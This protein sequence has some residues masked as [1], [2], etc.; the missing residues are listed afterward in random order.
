[1]RPQGRVVSRGS[2]L[3]ALGG[4][5]VQAKP[6]TQEAV[7][8]R[9]RDGDKIVDRL[10]ACPQDKVARLGDRDGDGVGDGCDAAP[11]CHAR[12]T[13]G[14]FVLTHDPIA[15]PLEQW[16]LPAVVYGPLVPL[17]GGVR[18]ATGAPVGRRAVLDRRT[19]SWR[20]L[21]ASVV[22]ASGASVVVDNLGDWVATPGFGNNAM[23]QEGRVLQ[24]F[25]EG[26]IEQ[27]RTVLD[28][29]SYTQLELART[30]EG[31]M[32]ALTTWEANG[33][34]NV[35][36]GRYN[37]GG[38]L[39]SALF[40]G[41]FSPMKWQATS[42]EG[43]GVAFYSEPFLNEDVLQIVIKGFPGSSRAA[44]VQERVVLGAP[45]D[46]LLMVTEA[47][48][49]VLWDKS[50]GKG[51]VLRKAALGA[52]YTP[53]PVPELDISPL[54][55]GARVVV[56]PEAMA[57]VVFE[58]GAGGMLEVKEVGF[59]CKLERLTFDS[60]MDG[61]PDLGDN[62][63][64][65]VN[66]NQ[67]DL[68]GD[69]QGDGCD[70][71][72]DGDG[73]ADVV[74]KRLKR[75]GGKDL[76]DASR[77]T[78]NDG[79]D[80]L[81]DPDDD[82]DGI[83]DETDRFPLDTD[84]DSSPNALDP[85]DD[86]D[87]DSDD[88]ERTQGSDPLDAMDFPQS[89]RLVYLRVAPG[90]GRSVEW[91]TF[92][93]LVQGKP[94]VPIPALGTKAHEPSLS[95]LGQSVLVLDGPP[96]M[97]MGVRW[98]QLVPPSQSPTRPAQQVELGAVQVQAAPQTMEEGGE[99]LLGVTHIQK[100]SDGIR[101]SLYSSALSP[102]PPQRVVAT[103]ALVERPG[104]V[105]A[106]YRGRSRL[107]VVAAPPGCGACRTAYEVN[108]AGRGI[109]AV[110]TTRTDVSW[111][112]RNSSER[113]VKASWVNE[114]GVGEARIFR[115]SSATPMRLPPGSEEVGTLVPMSR[116]G[117][118]IVTAKDASTGRFQLWF[119][120]DGGGRWVRLTESAE[121]LQEVDWKP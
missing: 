66:A 3:S 68:D 7:C 85:D 37:L 1:M 6:G 24:M 42:W 50:T 47:G 35:R 27:T 88:V 79:I 111:V 103:Q 26:G 60:D 4:T 20:E 82:G 70:E 93:D 18:A 64:R 72:D 14:E 90:G 52:T 97:A 89:G 10:D 11:L 8:I 57:L 121:S 69:G 41:T 65:V 25:Q 58:A 87:G 44:L 43:G 71:D 104:E 33:M 107:H 113:W 96:G 109:N 91:I 12:M 115:E 75:A 80:N 46:P 101:T 94:A 9:D 34:Q 45:I 120:P 39:T 100:H 67:A 73:L 22:D 86:E 36:I 77:D 59:G 99:V 48:A 98:S 92:G 74:D 61:V 21:E 63:P 30:K 110:F 62:C 17:I 116:L 105:S 106:L 78:D 5:W 55:P 108:E 15:W 19:G 40:T 83:A 13:P 32:M 117:R 56:A 2:T 16:G 38:A 118:A 54:E 23:G 119:T 51:Y 31:G 28:M 53:V 81:E 49:R 84:N 114:E 112:K 102:A 95:A 76:V 29:E